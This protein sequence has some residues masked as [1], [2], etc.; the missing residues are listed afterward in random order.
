M[1]AKDIMTGGITSMSADTTLLEAATFLVNMRVTAMPVL[2][3]DGVMVG[4]VTEADLIPYAG[5]EAAH[6]D[7]ASTTAISRQVRGRT[8]AEVMTKDVITVDENAPIKDV[9]TLMAGKRLKRVPV[10]SGT[11]IVGIISRIDLLRVIVSRARSDVGM[12]PA[13]AAMVRRDD[14]QLRHGVLAAIDTLDGR[15]GLLDV[16]AMAGIVHL[17]G[18]V[19]SREALEAYI[20]AA[21]QVPKVKSV[22]SHLQVRPR[23]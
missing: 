14:E 6:D 13:D 9:V 20:A 22:V 1:L 2:D 11:S 4:I 17:W 3:K 8:V 21:Q 7:A 12:S 15:A 23:R 16:V 5:L 18:A 19:P 10:R